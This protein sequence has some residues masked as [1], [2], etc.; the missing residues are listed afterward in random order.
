[1][2]VIWIYRV[3][4]LRNGDPTSILPRAFADAVIASSP[5]IKE[6]NIVTPIDEWVGNVYVL[7]SKI[8]ERQTAIRPIA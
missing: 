3:D 1:M 6:A 7:L 8:G 4:L 5:H 2:G